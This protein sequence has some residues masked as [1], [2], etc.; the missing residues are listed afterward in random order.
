MSGDALV[1]ARGLRFSY[2]AG[3]PVICGASLALRAGAMGALIGPNGCGKSTLIRL[4]ARLLT[5]SL[6]DIQF[7]GMPLSS[8]NQRVLA[9]QIGYVPQTTSRTFPF[10]ALEVV[11]TGRSPYISRFQFESNTDVEKARTA[12]ETVGISHLA[13]R[14]V[15]EL[16]GGEG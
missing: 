16:S 5:P 13:Q 3:R 7:G 8:I 15:T 9:K 11:L 4:L 10:T 1:E 14:P 12:L 6:G 2:A